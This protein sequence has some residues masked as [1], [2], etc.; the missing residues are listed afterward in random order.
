MPPRSPPPDQANLGDLEQVLTGFFD[1]EWY[2]NRYPDVETCGLEP[3]AHFIHWGAAEGRDPN[4]WF[5]S[6]R[7]MQ[8]YPDVAATGMPPLLHYMITGATELR[9]PHPRFDAAWYA[10]QHPEAAGNPL[11][12][13]LLFGKAR[14]WPTEPAVNVSDYLPSS[15][16]P[17]PCPADVQVDIVVPVYRGFAETRRCVES[18]LA[19]PGRPAGRVIVVDDHSPEADLS[20]WLNK[21]AAAG[22]I[23]LLRNR[24]NLGFVASV[25]R[26]IEAAGRH[27]VALLNSDTEVPGGWL[28]RLAA[29][30]YAGPRIASVSP[31]SNNATICGYPCDEGGPL[32]LGLDLGT[33][34]AACHTVN[35]GRSV[36]VP[37]TV[38]F[39]MYIRR[40]ALDAV[41]AFDVDAFGRGYGEENDFCMRASQRGWSHRLACDTFVFHEGAVSFRG[42]KDK[43][44]A[45]AMDTLAQRY[46]DYARI[47]DRHVK[48]NAVAPFRFAVTAALFRQMGLPVVLMLSHQLGGGVQRHI[49]ELVARLAGRANVF[50]LRESTR[51][52]ALSVPAL[53]TGP[54]LT[55]PAERLDDLVTVLESAGI[56]RA[57]V[58]HLIDTD[59]DARALI[60]RLGVPFDVTL[61][62]YF[63]ICPQVNLLPFPAAQYCGEPGPAACN[64]CIADRPSHGARDILSWRR[65][66][67]WLFLEAERVI[68]PS[69][70]ARARLARHGLAD[71][72]IVAPHEP[73]AAGPWAITPPPLKG[74]KLRVAVLGVLAD[75]KGAQTVT[76]VAEAADLATLEL[77]L[78]GH[79]EVKVPEAA[80]DRIVV[81]GAY[82]ESELPDLLAQV[83]PHV[84]WFPAQWP[85]TYSYTLSAAVAA[86]L[87]VVASC[88]GAFVERLH[89]RPLSW[90]VDPRASA[91]DWLR[92]FEQVRQA[93]ASPRPAA[94]VPRMAVRDFYATEYLPE[95]GNAGVRGKAA[96]R[97]VNL[98]RKGRTSIVVVPEQWDSG[99]FSPCAY[100]RLLQPLDH[101]AIGGGFD[102]VL[103]NAHEA[104]RYD[105]DIVVTQR[106]AVPDVVTADRLTAHCRRTGAALVYDLDDDLLHIPRDHPDAAL[107][108]PKAKVVQRLVRDA[109][110]VF[111]STPA[112]AASLKPMRRDA[113]L[114]PNALDER[115]WATLP[116]GSLPGRRTR[117][118]PVRLLC[119]GTATHGGDF[120]LIE[121]A[122]TRLHETFEGRVTIDVLGVST[123]ADLPDW[124]RRPTVPPGT[125]ATYPG[126]VNWITQQEGWDIGLAP[127]ADTAFNRCKSAIKT[128]DY[129]ALGLAVVASDVAPYRGSLADGPGG[130]LLPNRPEAWFAALSRL[131]RD[132]EL[133][134]GLARGAA[135][136]FA[137]DGTLARQAEARRAAWLAAVRGGERGERAA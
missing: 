130:M 40:A 120:A 75:Q 125:T 60:H 111:V 119:M 45:A 34:D 137:A 39:C 58:H 37:T 57:H 77:H 129:A 66:H 82:S 43:R 56:G 114:A 113:V 25:N 96:G 102:I 91:E 76:A 136:A 104:L 24:R 95:P 2:L 135:A 122:L 26:G 9:N 108:R 8:R 83:K 105:A 93:L 30:A 52:S 59:L 118:G 87:P 99:E 115:I 23:T 80:E 70:D 84:V 42:G 48:N 127:L 116:D 90:L 94:V 132:A 53:H 49:D 10:D 103:A 12:H 33:I 79:P 133:R 123:R 69:E 11:L 47:I 36:T 14:G 134:R 22:R 117:G 121:P 27:D 38:G 89:G 6:R 20:A 15:A 55:L 64:A 78:I 16:A 126:F 63:A 131:V 51:G 46:P 106:L 4:P 3:I 50:L 13:H 7:Y 107:L 81:T 101:P 17:L 124:A 5:D 71:R 54:L 85:E 21:L 32:P 74:R 73:V 18:V 61:H 62:D 28:R 44:E 1:A 35:A 72:A 100:I 68:C 88:I 29:Q 98:R 19:D 97:L 92:C 67:G 31:F 128:L 112:L 110:L 86:G 109:G 65:R 41:G